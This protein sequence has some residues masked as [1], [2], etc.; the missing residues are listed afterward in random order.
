M[1]EASDE[2]LQALAR[3]AYYG[4]VDD[5]P[6]DACGGCKRCLKHL[7]DGTMLK[8]IP[9][10]HITGRVAVRR[11]KPGGV[12]RLKAKIEKMGYL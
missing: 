8:T 1:I 3:W 6:Q 9:I 12:Q 4:I 7:K 2:E 10:A 11:I 5:C